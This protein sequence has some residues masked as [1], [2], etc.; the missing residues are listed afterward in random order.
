MVE[1]E[2]KKM[3]LLNFTSRKPR[4]IQFNNIKVRP[5]L[6]NFANNPHKPKMGGGGLKNEMMIIK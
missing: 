5:Y 2:V 6:I 3:K 1:G 4:K